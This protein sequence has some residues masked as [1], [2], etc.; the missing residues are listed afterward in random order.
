[1]VKARLDGHMTVVSRRRFA[2]AD[3]H[4]VADL[5]ICAV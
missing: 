4:D 3:E 5:H 2:I 1:M